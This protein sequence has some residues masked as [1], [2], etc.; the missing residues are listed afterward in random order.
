MDRYD[1]AGVGNDPGSRD[2]M[3][4]DRRLLRVTARELI[5]N[6]APKAA[7]GGA[8]RQLIYPL[9]ASA[10]CVCY[11][12]PLHRCTACKQPRVWSLSVRIPH[13]LICKVWRKMY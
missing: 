10:I 1:V 13:N 11:S 9:F 7:A 3:C 6:P 12:R 4:H 8:E 5:G 2:Q